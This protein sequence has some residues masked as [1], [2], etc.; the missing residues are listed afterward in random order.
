[1]S[2]FKNSQITTLDEKPIN[3]LNLPDDSLLNE[4][5]SGEVIPN[6][7]EVEDTKTIPRGYGAGYT[8]YT[9]YGKC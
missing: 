6:L 5:F 8:V 1:M 9:K 7:E 2:Q 4:W 3:V